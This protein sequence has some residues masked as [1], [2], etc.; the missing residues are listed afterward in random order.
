ME[1][2]EEQELEEQELFNPWPELLEQARKD[3]GLSQENS[4]ERADVSVATWSRWERGGVYPD[5]RQL[6][7]MAQGVGMSADELGLQYAVA[8]L[9]HYQGHVAPSGE[10]AQKAAA[11]EAL[12]GAIEDPATATIAASRVRGF[13]SHS[14][15]VWVD[16]EDLL[17]SISEVRS[18]R[19][20]RLH[21]RR[22]RFRSRRGR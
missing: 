1:S 21:R 15:A 16:V 18:S 19:S 6:E 5:H 2:Q 12:A 10:G 20:G 9:R 17:V 14:G 8:L 22:R 13:R 11:M 3:K 4:A 7:K